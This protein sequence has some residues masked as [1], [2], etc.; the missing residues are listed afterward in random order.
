MGN[1]VSIVDAEVI[2]GQRTQTKEDIQALQSVQVFNEVAFEASPKNESLK[3]ILT[4]KYAKA[5][6]IK[7]L[8]TCEDGRVIRKFSEVSLPDVYVRPDFS[9]GSSTELIID[10]YTKPADE[11]DVS[12]LEVE[13]ISNNIR[14]LIRGERDFTNSE[15]F[16]MIDQAKRAEVMILL[17][18]TL[19]KFFLSPEFK[20]W[21]ECEMDRAVT[22][23]LN[24]SNVDAT[25]PEILPADP[26][27]L[28]GGMII[29]AEAEFVNNIPR[30]EFADEKKLAACKE[31]HSDKT[32]A[33]AV[34]SYDGAMDAVDAALNGVD[35]LEVDRLLSCGSWLFAFIASCEK[36]PICITLSTASRSRV[37]FPLIYVNAFFETV[38]GYSR[39]EIMGA[40]CKFLQRDCSGSLRS[41]VDS[42]QRL[43]V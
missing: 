39:T 7:Y 1:T 5:A 34:N 18:N 31:D 19:P 41:E 35:Y 10:M 15:V 6:F 12:E 30:G 42:V 40:N 38:T 9:R 32:E 13:S 4:D 24:S 20:E 28:G 14:A 22:I 37:G 36:L 27:L 21:R 33:I 17:L 29:S 16:D 26:A 3:L 8:S 2:A 43:S 23:S 11:I 25:L